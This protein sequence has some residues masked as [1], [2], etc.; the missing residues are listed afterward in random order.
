MSVYDLKNVSRQLP[1]SEPAGQAASGGGQRVNLCSTTRPGEAS[2]TPSPPPQA[3]GTLE[4][5]SPPAVRRSIIRATGFS[6]LALLLTTPFLDRGTLY[7]SVSFYLPLAVLTLILARLERVGR[8]VLA[9]WILCFAVF[10]AVCTGIYLFGGIR[11]Q[12]AIAFG[13]VIVM[14]ALMIASRGLI[15]FSILSALA[16]GAL[17]KAD[18]FNLIPEPIKTVAPNALLSAILFNLAVIVAVL[19]SGLRAFAATVV[20]LNATNLARE[21]DLRELELLQHRT[22][23]KANAARGIA[24]IGEEVIRGENPEWR[25]RVLKMIQELFSADGIGLFENPSG[26]D[27]YLS[28]WHGSPDPGVEEA[29]KRLGV[30]IFPTEGTTHAERAAEELSLDLESPL[31]H[32]SS[33]HF[34]SIPGRSHNRGFLAILL[35]ER[36]DMTTDMEESLS[37][38]RSILGSAMERNHVEQKMRV[39]QRL[40]TVGRLAGSVAHDFNN[41]LT[42]VTTCSDL[43]FETGGKSEQ[44]LELLADI[45]TA[46]DHA[47]LFTRQLLMLS[48]GQVA[49]ES[50]INLDK[51]I[52]RFCGIADR[53]VG[54]SITIQFDSSAQDCMIF[55]DPSGIEQILLNL[56][57]NSRD[58]LKNGGKISISLSALSEEETRRECPEMRTCGESLRLHF[59][60]NGPGF[61]P[62]VL[63]HLFEPFFTTRKTGTGLGLATVKQAVDELNGHIEAS[64]SPEKGALFSIYLPRLKGKDEEILED[65]IQS[66][67]SAEGREVLVVEDNDYV[68]KTIS[69]VLDDAGYGV[70]ICH[71]GQEAWEL[72]TKSETFFDVILTDIVMP[73]LSGIDFVSRIRSTGVE[74]PVL[75][76]SG[77]NDSSQVEIGA[78]GEFIAKPFASEQLLSQLQRISDGTPPSLGI[79]PRENLPEP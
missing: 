30:E 69:R 61:S 19:Q 66:L 48:R 57:V 17:V 7:T 47:S 71:D 43:L 13:T 5:T 54:E 22:E 52:R 51:T 65:P 31:L 27:P 63:K 10:I 3:A 25:P 50:P 37:S 77:F 72:L 49:V 29:V 42:T 75:F 62:H 21:D 41:L 23:E 26:T 74:T 34:I 56:V 24:E 28:T 8:G 73:N 44:D 14:A 45:S 39:A 16:V 60:D 58:A 76:M 18:E 78:L 33:V 2:G 67:H 79:R 64:S 12:T 46:A 59:L 1:W 36:M 40:E 6:A 20:Q 11:E 4:M 68:L 9:A 55:A 32:S 53:M 70:T 38:L 35:S 15:V